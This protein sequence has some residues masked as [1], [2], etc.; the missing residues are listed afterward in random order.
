MSAPSVSPE[1]IWHN[2]PHIKF[3]GSPVGLSVGLEE[4]ARLGKAVGDL[5]GLSVGLEECAI[6]GESVGDL[7]G[8]FV[9][10]AFVGSTVG[11]SAVHIGTVG[12]VRRVK[13]S[14]IE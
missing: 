7:V 3:I 12:C 9:V 1:H 8:V 5:V 13:L 6:L 10:G 4:G 14:I 11:A 2:A